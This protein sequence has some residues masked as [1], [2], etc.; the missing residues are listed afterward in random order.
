M[1]IAY[2]IEEILGIDHS[3]E[4]LKV[5][6]EKKKLAITREYFN[7]YYNQREIAFALEIKSF[8]AYDE[9]IN[10]YITLERFTPPQSFC[11]VRHGLQ[12]IK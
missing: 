7:E 1:E 2:K 12:M 4:N 8:V 5:I 11:Y 9:P 3:N 6:I 10:P